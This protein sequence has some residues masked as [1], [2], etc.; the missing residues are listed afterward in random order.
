[1]L[2]EDV[3]EEEELDTPTQY[4]SSAQNPDVQSD[5]IAGFHA[6]NCASVIP[7]SAA[8]MAQVSFATQ[9]NRLVVY[10]EYNRVKFQEPLTLCDIVRV[11][12]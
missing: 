8:T 11:A 9:R 3:M 10:K 5:E 2:V 6:W 1:M 4:A 12:V 7:K